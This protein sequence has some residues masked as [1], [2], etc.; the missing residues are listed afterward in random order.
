MFHMPTD[1]SVI[2]DKNQSSQDIVFICTGIYMFNTYGY[3][4][5]SLTKKISIKR[6]AVIIKRM[7]ALDWTSARNF[8]SDVST[9]YLNDIPLIHLIL[10]GDPN[11]P[12]FD[13]QQFYLVA[14]GIN[15]MINMLSWFGVIVA[16]YSGPIVDLTSCQMV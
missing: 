7:W 14:K 8:T 5:T 6:P 3:N 12:I 2:L 4:G 15:G 13:F 9:K 11:Y 10:H 16:I 1:T